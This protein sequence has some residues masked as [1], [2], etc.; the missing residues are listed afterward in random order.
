MGI[1]GADVVESQGA[2]RCQ[3]SEYIC[4]YGIEVDMVHAE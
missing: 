4:L 1:T 3:G 2:I